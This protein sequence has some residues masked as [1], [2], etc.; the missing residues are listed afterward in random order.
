MARTLERKLG[1]AATTAAN[2]TRMKPA[3]AA[4]PRDARQRLV[5]LAVAAD[6]LDDVIR[7]EVDVRRVQQREPHREVVPDDVVQEREHALRVAGPDSVRFAMPPGT[8][9]RRIIF[10]VRIEQQVLV[11]A[12]ARAL[13]R[14]ASD[15]SSS[16]GVHSSH[17]PNRSSVRRGIAA[18]PPIRLSTRFLH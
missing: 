2:T 3:V 9:R 5:L 11:V 16:I 6:P 8:S 18:L 4:D 7:D 15:G 12:L 17:R 13:M 14:Y 10:D 1:N